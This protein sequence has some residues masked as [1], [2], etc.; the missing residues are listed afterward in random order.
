M[1]YVLIRVHK[2]IWIGCSNQSI[3][4]EILNLDCSSMLNIFDRF[5]KPF[6]FE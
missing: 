1:T 3:V 4:I 2:S 6:S 5:I